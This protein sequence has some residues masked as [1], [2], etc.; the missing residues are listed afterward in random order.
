MFVCNSCHAHTL[1]WAGKCPNCG[2]WNTLE[3]GKN[4]TRMAKKITGKAR[5]THK[6]I[7]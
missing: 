4:E 2:E 6:I 7:P 3:E 5:A 1:K